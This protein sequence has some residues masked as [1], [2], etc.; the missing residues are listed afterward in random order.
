MRISESWVILQGKRQPRN[1]VWAILFSMAQHNMG[2]LPQEMVGSQRAYHVFP[3]N[4][5]KR[6]SPQ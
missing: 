5:F 1:D 6:R 4:N 2:T 3:K